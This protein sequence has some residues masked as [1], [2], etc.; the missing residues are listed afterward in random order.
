MRG[1]MDRECNELKTALRI[2]QSRQQALSLTALRTKE[3]ASKSTSSPKKKVENIQA[4]R[5][6]NEHH[7][8][9]I[10]RLTEELQ[11]SR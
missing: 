4:I 7:L 10:A 9:E 2:A 6:H 5:D 11:H 3:N 1:A 8:K